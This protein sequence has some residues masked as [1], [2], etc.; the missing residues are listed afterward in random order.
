M[1]TIDAR[2][3]KTIITMLCETRLSLKNLILRRQYLVHKING[4]KE[5]RSNDRDLNSWMDECHGGPVKKEMDEE[6]LG[7]LDKDLF[8][9]PIAFDEYQF[10]LLEDLLDVIE[11]RIRESEL[12]ITAWYQCMKVNYDCDHVNVDRTMLFN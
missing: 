3:I 9:Y 8:L 4:I 2:H 5:R 10:V 6:D 11:K 7:K 12:C 1:D